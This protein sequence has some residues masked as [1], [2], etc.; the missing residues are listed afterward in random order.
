MFLNALCCQDAE[1]LVDAD[2]L[3]GFARVLGHA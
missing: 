1:V 2:L 3:A